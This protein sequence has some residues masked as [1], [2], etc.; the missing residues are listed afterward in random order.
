MAN[1][2]VS[3]YL[4]KAFEKDFTTTDEAG[5]TFRFYTQ[6]I[7]D[8][9]VK[10]GLIIACDALLFQDDAPFTTQFPKGVFPVELSI[11]NIAD[12][13]R[14]GFARIKFSEE[15]PA[16]WTLATIEGHDLAELG[17]DDIFGYGVDSGTGSFMD[18][19]AGKNLGAFLD[20]DE[21]NYDNLAAEMRKNYKDTRDWLMWESN[22]TNVALF[23]SGFGDGLYATYIGKDKAGNICRLVTDFAIV[24]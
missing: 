16:D 5:D 21:D 22:D 7:G 10:E 23:S 6:K 14:V 9:K 8:L 11:A 17:E 1:Y 3:P 19:S 24:E 20:A 4:E 18:V 2:Y 13:E 12:D 15:E